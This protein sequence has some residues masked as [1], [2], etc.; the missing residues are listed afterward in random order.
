METQGIV[1]LVYGFPE[2]PSYIRENVKLI[3][4]LQ[5]AHDTGDSY[6]IASFSTEGY[7]NRFTSSYKPFLDNF[8]SSLR[9]IAAKENLD[10]TKINEAF[11]AT[12]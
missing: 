6:I 2:L 9:V 8:M 1:T 11:E 7:V 3:G 12:K 5:N 4:M 10:M